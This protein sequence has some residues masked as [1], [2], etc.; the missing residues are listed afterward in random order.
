MTPNQFFFCYLIHNDRFAELYEYVDKVGTFDKKEIDDLLKRG[1]I[2]NINE[3]GK[4]TADAFVTTEKFTR[5]FLANKDVL[6]KEFMEAYPSFGNIDGKPIVLKSI[7]PDV[8]FKLYN[9]I[10]NR[11]VA[12][13][14]RIMAALEKGKTLGLVNMKIEKWLESRQWTFIEKDLKYANKPGDREFTA[15]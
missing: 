2:E 7:L 14:K 6:A 9:N 15:D 4:F 13:H 12:E 1:Y 3:N 8:L 11:E 5:K 10:T